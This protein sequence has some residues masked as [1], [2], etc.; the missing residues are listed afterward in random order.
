MMNKTNFLAVAVIA[1][2]AFT[3]VPAANATVAGGM[4]AAT[5]TTTT[6]A[7]TTAPSGVVLAHGRRH[8]WG[9]GWGH[10]HRGFRNCRWLKRKAR[11]TGRRY[12]WHRYHRCRNAY[13]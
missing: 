12:W 1:A 9:H 11:R 3:A 4:S 5:A 6:A 13:Y 2:A 8:G 7:T 10:G